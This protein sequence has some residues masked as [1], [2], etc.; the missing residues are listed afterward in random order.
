MNDPKLDRKTLVCYG[1]GN[2]TQISI[3]M[4]IGFYIMEFYTDVIH[5]SSHL[6]GYALLI[7]YMLS[8]ITNV[9][10]GYVSDHTRWR[11]GRRRPYFLI[12]TLP[13]GILFFFVFA[14]PNLS[15]PWLFA[16]FTVAASLLL[17]AIAVF[18][19]PYNALSPELTYDYN[20]R[21]R[22]SAYRRSLELCG[23]ILGI[24]TL[25][26]LLVLHGNVPGLG[27]M[28]EKECYRLV[29]LL[30][31]VAA[32]AAGILCF[33][34]TW[35]RPQAANR[36]SYH[37]G[38][39]IKGCLHNRPFVLIVVAFMLTVIADNITLSQLLY[40]IES[41]LH[42]KKEDMAAFMFVFFIGSLA[43]V[44]LW[45][46]LGNVLGKKWCYIVTMLVYPLP[47]SMLAVHPWSDP[48]LY[49]IGLCGGVLNAGLYM[50]P[51]ALMPDIVEWDEL[52]TH[53]RREGVYMGIWIF[54]FKLGIGLSFL[55]VGL[56]L[57]LIGYNVE[58]LTSNVVNSLRLNF[59]L[60]PATIMVGAALVFS[61]FPITKA[62][63]AE[64]V[65]ELAD[66]HSKGEGMVW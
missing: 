37:Y 23:E 6:V 26:L 3:F 65:K 35:E 44:P 41:F 62:K 13:A 20:E 64:I 60:L 19:T 29:A 39:A 14:P 63:H 18:E 30:I 28:D 57:D 31:G 55:A 47:F 42:K 48:A 59:A 27:S 17:I 25:P 46:K 21:I 38:S 33:W 9:V 2:V 53:Q 5:L 54:S 10:M 4:F 12:G 52:H 34:G 51:V 49:T 43:S 40:I 16:Y 58:H 56:N 61:R 50:M 66:R 32:V 11:V 45:M 22:L 8:A 7:A 36:S 15:E 24:F 1:L